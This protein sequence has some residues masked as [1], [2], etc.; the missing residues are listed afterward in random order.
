MTGQGLATGEPT[1]P[2]FELCSIGFNSHRH[3]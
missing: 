2:Y 1:L 3:R